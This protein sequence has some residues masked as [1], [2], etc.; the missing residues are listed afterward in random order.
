MRQKNNLQPRTVNSTSL[1]TRIAWVGGAAFVMA[2]TILFL[3]NTPSGE[4]SQV[5]PIIGRD[6]ALTLASEDTVLNQYTSLANDASAGSITLVV[7]DIDDLSEGGALAG[8]DLVL[9]IQMQGASITLDDDSTFGSISAYNNAGNYEFSYVAGTTGN[10]IELSCGLIHDYTASGHAQVIRVPQYTRLTIEE[11]ASVSAKDWDGSSGGVVA[12]VAQELIEVSGSISAAGKG[13]RGGEVDNNTAY[14][15]RG[16]FYNSASSG[17]EKGEGIAGFQAEYDA[18]SARYGRGAPANGGG[19]G[20]AHNAGGGGGANG[21]NGAEWNGQGTM[22]QSCIGSSAWQLDSGYIKH[23]NTFTTSGG[24]GRGGYTYGSSNQDALTL[25]PENNSWGGDKRRQLGGLGG[26]SVANDPAERIFMGGGGGSGDGN[27]S[28]A[29]GGASGGGIVVLVTNEVSGAGTVDAAGADANP[30]QSGH[31]D[32]PGGGGGGGTIIIKANTTSGIAVNA[33]GGEGG[34]QL[35]TGNESEG[36]G[37]GGGGGFIAVPSSASVTQSVLG[38]SGGISN[39]A[40]IT[41]FPANGATE[42]APG[43]LST[44]IAYLPFCTSLDH[45]GDGIADSEDLDDDNDGIPDWEE[46][47]CTVSD[48]GTNACKDPADKTDAGIPRYQDASECSGG[49]LVNGVCPEYDTDGDGIPDFLDKDADNDGI[50]DLIEAGGVDQS[51][52]GLVD[53]LS[54]ESAQYT[55]TLTVT[56]DA[57]NQSSSTEVISLGINPPSAA[58]TISPGFVNST[59]SISLDGAAS[60]DDGSI[61]AYSWDFG[62]GTSGTGSSAS[63]TYSDDGTYTVALTVTDNEGLTDTYSQSVLVSDG[64][65]CAMVMGSVY[66]EYWSGISGT[67]ISSLTS[68]A[69]YPDNPNSTSSLTSFSGPVNLGSNYGTRV[70]GYVVAPTTGDYYFTVTADDAVSVYLSTDQD[71]A[72]MTEICGHTG[73]TNPGQMDRY[74]SQRSSAISLTADGIYYIE[75]LH[76]EGGGGDHFDVYWERPDNATPTIIAGTYLAPFGGSCADNPPTPVISASVVSGSHPLAVSFSATSSVDADGSINS[77]V[78]S[79]GEGTSA[80]GATASHTFSAPLSLTDIDQDGWCDIYDNYNNGGSG[81][82]GG[83]PLPYLDSDRDGYRDFQD[84]DADNDGITDLFESGNFANDPDEDGMLGT[85]GSAPTDTDGDGLADLVDP[86]DDSGGGQTG[87]PRVVTGS[88]AIASNQPA[89]FITG[90]FDSDGVPD[91]RDVDSDDDGILDWMEAQ[92]SGTTSPT[93]GLVSP[94]GTDSDSDGIDDAFDVK[95]RVDGTSIGG[96]AMDPPDTDS[97]GKY[98][99]ADEDADGDEISDLIE[100]NDLDNDGVSD[101][102]PSGTDIDGDGLDDAFDELTDTEA[103]NYASQ[104]SMSS[105]VGVQDSDNE[106]DRDWREVNDSPIS[107]PVEWMYFS[108]ELVNGDGYLKWATAKEINSFYFDVE[109]SVDGQVFEALDQVQAAGF[110]ESTT[111]YTFVDI[112][113]TQL[114]VPAVMYRLK[115]VDLDGAYEYSNRVELKLEGQADPL[116]RVLLYPNPA[117]ESATVQFTTVEPGDWQLRVIT[118]TGRQVHS[119]QISSMGGTMEIPLSCGGWGAGNYVV[120][121]TNGTRNLSAKLQVR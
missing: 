41:E 5:I 117:R 120:N 64:D 97:D 93:D 70:R 84:L 26:R 88:A 17:G 55:V 15:Q 113:L 30:T 27:N 95:S 36:P 99:F 105:S 79:F 100:G 52:A 43:E 38:G 82:S 49:S 68:N 78:W 63:H 115:Q 50:P 83:S 23:S 3:T 87:T 86:T 47:G 11:G 89:S 114:S 2:F 21:N 76:K 48:F 65:P 112:S 73:W 58:Y 16:Y 8:D 61:A 9:I 33:D 59:L 75:L 80:T 91:Y 7:N 42:G 13:F 77:Y 60:A 107:M 111:E 108:G 29:T 37:G 56:D 20:N 54:R 69:N 1:K 40:S 94:T 121:L 31:N 18:A 57:G 102:S 44:A 19:G 98:D 106:N 119:Q 22:C 66:R 25:A 74:S 116:S 39:S 96:N 71:P 12:I 14:N 118:L 51:G 46:L 81:Y 103:V 24:G 92:A 72:N 85:Y 62:D 10:Q 28:A 90:D 32:A 45:D 53:C 4:V 35:I 109:R 67:S 104:N 101:V 6:G 110:S 34:E